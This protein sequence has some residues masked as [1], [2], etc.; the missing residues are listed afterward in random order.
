VL[1]DELIESVDVHDDHLE[2]IVRS[3]PGL[4]IELA[5]VGLGRQGESKSCRRGDLNPHA[6][7]GTRPST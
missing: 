2:V 7:A 1:I 4:N 5:E 6:L 3:A